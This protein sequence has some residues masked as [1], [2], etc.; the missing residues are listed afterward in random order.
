MASIRAFLKSVT[1]A[2]V[3]ETYRNVRKQRSHARNRHRTTEAVF[4]EIYQKNIW[5][6]EPGTFCSGTGSRDSAV[7]EPYIESMKRELGRIGAAHLTAV[8]LG[9]G[10]YSIGA[11]LSASCGHYI[12]IDVVRA[13]VDHNNARFG[14]DR[15][16][17]H[18]ID[19]VRD[20]LPAG[21]ICF[22]RQ[23]LQH[24]SND[25]IVT[26][27]AKLHQYRYVF[28][29]EHLPS[30]DRLVQKNMDKPHGGD[31]RV[32][33]GSGVFLGTSPF[34]VAPRLLQHILD[35]PGHEA[36]V[37]QDPGIIRTYLLTHGEAVS[38]LGKT[39]GAPAPL[40]PR[41]S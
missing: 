35:V 6:G 12:G 3:L 11:R 41:E 18:H 20:E 28:I 40:P 14:N 17:F 5:G 30:P 24:L 38:D 4:T 2:L 13:L 25:Q 21:D 23:V 15:V 34:L 26:V 27:L 31:I 10:D 37:G 1:P 19:I 16:L 29:T 33:S 9:C 36:P 32:S 8:D 39:S 7:V 22:V